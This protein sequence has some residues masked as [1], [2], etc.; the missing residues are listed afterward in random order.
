[1]IRALLAA[2]LLTVT[3]ALAAPLPS[4]PPVKPLTAAEAQ[5]DL[6]I[7]RKALVEIHPGNDRFV[8]IDALEAEFARAQA[9]VA[10]GATQGHMYLIASRLAAFVRCGHTWTNPLNQRGDVQAAVFGAADK[11]PLWLKRVAGRYL[12]T[13]SSDPRVKAGDELLSIDGRAM[14]A[15]TAEMLPYLRADG[16]SDGKRLAQLDTDSNGGALDRLLPLLHAPVNGRYTL[17]VADRTG[18]SRVVSVAATSITARDALLARRGIQPRRDD[19]AFRVDA[20]GIA[21]LTMPTFA[22]W[23]DPFDWKAAIDRAFAE[24]D[25]G[26]VRGLVLDLR[27]NEGGSDTIGD[28]VLAHLIKALYTK[29]AAVPY[30]RYERM[31]YTLSRYFDTWDYDY[32]DRTGQVTKLAERWYRADNRVEPADVIQPIPGLVAAGKVPTVA[33]TGPQMSSAGYI[34]ARDLRDSGAAH[35]IGRTTGGNRRGLNG[36][37]LAWLTL[38]ASGV[39]VDIPLISW[40]PTSDQP[41]IGIV[42]DLDVPEDFDAARA[43][44]DVEMEAARAWLADAAR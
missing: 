2:A 42:P 44:R 29:P 37:E 27:N 16:S 41:D 32:F 8:T 36:G 15:L 10:N 43:G 34:I 14:T 25:S 24:V 13:A 1:M 28:T 23:N 33:L 21:V 12:V 26:R 5:R 17:Q 3:T 7:L 20:D 22:F 39:A 40:R 19:W 6:R 18:K 30:V 38:P 31:P 9:E 4:Q 35:L 11:L